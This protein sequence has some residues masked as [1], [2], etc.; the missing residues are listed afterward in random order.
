MSEAN[1]AEAGNE[2]VR[3]ESDAEVKARRL[4]WVPKEEFKGDPDKHRSAEEF[5][6][7]GTNLL[8]LLQ[9]DNE[10][11]H[12][13]VD[14]VERELR[15]T[16]EVLTEFR[17]FAS[18]SEERA[19]KRAKAELE[20]KLDTAIQSADVD[21]A[22]QARREIAAL[23][24]ER[25]VKPAAEKKEAE[26]P[27]VDPVFDAWLSENTW[28]N[29]DPALQGFATKVFGQLE[30][31]QPGRSP[32]ELLAET[33]K[34]VMDKFPEE[35]GINPKREAAASVSTPNGGTAA[36]KKKGKTY[37]DLPAE[38]KKACDKFVKTIPG[39]TRDKYVAQYDWD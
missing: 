11:L 28:F 33:K 35:F 21:T 16:K 2:E 31:A 27:K 15:E 25:V 1:L 3:Q 26:K 8:P 37:D 36:P 10:R 23:E 19:Y 29:T 6:E 7:R 5:L 22:R 18:K 9:R 12:R 14:K 17:D 39:Y 20:T 4:G 38:A 32:A 34:K 13:T 24:E 30:K